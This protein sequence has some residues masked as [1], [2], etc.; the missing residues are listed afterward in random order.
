[1]AVAIDERSEIVE[2]VPGEIEPSVLLEPEHDEVAV[3]VVDLAEPP[4]W[5]DIGPAQG[6]QRGKRVDLLR[7]APQRLPRIADVRTHVPI[8]R[9]AERAEAAQ[10]L[11]EMRI[12]EGFEIESGRTFLTLVLGHDLRGRLARN[13]V[14]EGFLIRKEARHLDRAIEIGESDGGRL[15]PRGRVR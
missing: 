14:G 6:Q 11:I 5:D 15:R 2:R 7:F 9:W 10:R 1:M 13:S 12:D 4:A 8:R 3:P